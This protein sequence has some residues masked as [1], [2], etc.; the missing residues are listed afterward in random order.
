MIIPN[1]YNPSDMLY[2]VLFIMVV[3]V[4]YHIFFYF[5]AKKKLKN[6]RRMQRMNAYE[7]T[8]KNKSCQKKYEDKDME[9]D[10]WRELRN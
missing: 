10:I 9:I 8:T 1:G 4:A 6:L 7:K 5:V 2:I 3:F